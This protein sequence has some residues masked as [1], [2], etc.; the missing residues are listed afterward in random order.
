[1]HLIPASDALW[2][3]PLL[4]PSHLARDAVRMR[5]LGWDEA[6]TPRGVDALLKA[7]KTHNKLTYTQVRE[8]LHGQGLPS[9]DQAHVHM[10]YYL[11]YHGLICRGPDDGRQLTYTLLEDWIGPLQPLPKDEALARLA[12]RYLAAYAPATMKD[13]MAWS[14]LP[15]PDA[16]AGWNAVME[17]TVE[18]VIGD[19]PY[20]IL[21]THADLAL[22][23]LTD[24]TVHLLPRFDQYI[25]G[26]HDRGLIMPDA[27]LRLYN[28]GGGMANALVLVNGCVKG[29][30]YFDRSRKNTRLVVEPFEELPS[31]AWEEIE[32]LVRGMER[33]LDERLEPVFPQTPGLSG[34]IR[35]PG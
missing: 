1:L 5:Q 4:K 32:H 13:F 15:A 28:A 26:Y 17:H 23:T 6:N 27:Y 11:S 34:L 3:I 20:R 21:K 8:V 16:R 12:Q 9:R 35:K 29:A 25:L 18:V 33:F 10:L 19:K 30:W 7:M 31:T 14:G 2:I 24:P 22:P